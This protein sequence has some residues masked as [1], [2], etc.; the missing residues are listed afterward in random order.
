MTQRLKLPERLSVIAGFISKRASVIDIG[1]DHGFLPVYLA[2]NSSAARIIATDISEGSLN[3]ARRNAAKYG[4]TASIEFILTP[5][6][7]GIE[8]KKINTIVIAGLGG[9]TIASILS[10]AVWIKERRIKLILQ[11]QSKIDELCGFLRLFGYIFSNAE[12][13]RDNGRYYIVIVAATGKSESFESP[14][15]ELY[16]IISKK[17]N[18]LLANYIDT[19]INKTQSTAA[20]SKISNPARYGSMQIRLEELRSIKEVS[21]W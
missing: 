2:Q 20:A 18:P 1:T 9:E 14:E 10:K 21:H 5:G 11:P 19:L 12:V 4:V 16:S 6:L 3:A 8:E 15:M 17:R 7:D 13:V